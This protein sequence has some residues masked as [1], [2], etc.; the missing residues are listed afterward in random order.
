[1]SSRGLGQPLVVSLVVT[2]AVCVAWVTPVWA[3]KTIPYRDRAQGTLLELLPDRMDFAAQGSATLFGKYSI[4]G[5][6]NYDLMGNVTGGV[7]TTTTEDG[8]TIS[9][10]Y[11]GTYA[12][13]PDGS[14]LFAV[15]VEWLVGTGRLAGVTG[16]AEFHAT[17]DTLQPGA[18]VRYVGRGTLTL[19]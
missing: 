3:G 13:Q 5:S 10:I 16:T 2:L 6:H 15:F 7:F 1:M 19:P 18:T 8:A 4:E 11:S 12:L 14:V 17:L 9:G